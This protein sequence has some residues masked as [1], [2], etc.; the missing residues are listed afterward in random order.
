MHLFYKSEII[1]I[2]N[3]GG[4]VETTEGSTAEFLSRYAEE[5][6]D[7]VGEI[8]VDGGIRKKRDVQVAKQLGATKCLVARPWISRLVKDGVSGMTNAIQRLFT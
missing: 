2:S 5:L 8:W 1:V 4:R 7:Y 6:K 3:H